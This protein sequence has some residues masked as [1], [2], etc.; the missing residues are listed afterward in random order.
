MTTDDTV[1]EVE[2][3]P[4][5]E[6][7]LGGED[8]GRLGEAEILPALVVLPP[9]GGDGGGADLHLPVPDPRVLKSVADPY[10]FISHPSED[11]R[12]DS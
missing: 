1:P 9:E 12:R 7:R 4:E 2:V 3:V 6:G 10:I 8:V 5:E 11:R